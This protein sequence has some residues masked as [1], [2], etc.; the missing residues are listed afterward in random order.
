MTWSAFKGAFEEYERVGDVLILRR[1]YQDKGKVIGFAF[2]RYRERF[3]MEK[4]LKWG[5]HQ[6]LDGRRVMV[7]RAEP[8][9]KFWTKVRKAPAPTMRDGQRN[10]ARKV[11]SRSFKEVVLQQ[12]NVVRKEKGFEKKIGKGK[13]NTKVQTTSERN[14]GIVLEE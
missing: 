9:K 5:S 4:A 14:G 7:S 8:M 12:G 2:I 3:E 1:S 13:D 10:M 6:W 11:D